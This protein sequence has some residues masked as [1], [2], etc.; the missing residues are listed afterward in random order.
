MVE[1]ISIQDSLPQ[2]PLPC[3]IGVL[4]QQ[5]WA[6]LPGPWTPGNG[7]GPLVSDGL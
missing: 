5:G 1:R 7:Q 4:E 3:L 2:A 6:S